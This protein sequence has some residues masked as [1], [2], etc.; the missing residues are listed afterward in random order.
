M[1]C[2]E[3]LQTVHLVKNHHF[4]KSIQRRRVERVLEHPC[5]QSSIRWEA[6]DCGESCVHVANVFGLWRLG[7]ERLV[8]PLACVPSV[9]NEPAS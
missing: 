3:D 7:E 6:S 5:S 1:I 9:R 2:H 8:R 4:A